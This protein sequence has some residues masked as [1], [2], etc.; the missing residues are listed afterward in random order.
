MAGLGMVIASVSTFL[1]V[2][3]FEPWIY[4]GTQLVGGLGW[5]MFNNGLVN[6]LFE[7]VPPDDRPPHMAWFNISA[8]AAVLLCGLLSQQLVGALGLGGSMLLAVG[9]RLIAGLMMLRF[10]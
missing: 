7:N 6:Y 10:G 3:S 9:F 4:F 5:A 1:F 2:V 8:N